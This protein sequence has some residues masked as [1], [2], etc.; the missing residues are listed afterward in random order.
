LALVDNGGAR[1]EGGAEKSGEMVATRTMVA[2]AGVRV[3]KKVGI[4]LLA[5]GFLQGGG[6]RSI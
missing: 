3:L 6:E 1:D 5:G 4:G 2:I